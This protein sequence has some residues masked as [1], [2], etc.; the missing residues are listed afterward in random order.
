VSAYVICHPDNLRTLQ[1]LARRE[2]GMVT[3]S[4]IVGIGAALL[5]IPV[6]TDPKMPRW[7]SRW[8]PPDWGPL[9][10]LGSEDE[11]SLRPAGFGEVRE[12]PGE[13]L[14]YWCDPGPSPAVDRLV[15]SYLHREARR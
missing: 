2:G 7:V 15:K 1:S 8:V 13:P 5:G 6:M 11:A 14:Y 12:I 4:M 9:W 3:D 10:D